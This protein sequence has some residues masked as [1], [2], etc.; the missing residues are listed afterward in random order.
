MSTL[1]QQRWTA[2]EVIAQN[3]ERFTVIDFDFRP[4]AYLR[5]FTPEEVDA[6]FEV[7][8]IEPS[9]TT[10]QILE[11]YK[12]AAAEYHPDVIGTGD[13]KLFVLLQVAKRIAVA[14]VDVNRQHILW[15]GGAELLDCPN[16]KASTRHYLAA[17][18]I[19]TFNYRCRVCKHTHISPLSTTGE[20][21]NRGINMRRSAVI[22]GCDIPLI[23][24]QYANLPAY[25]RGE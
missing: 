5:K 19:Y 24:Q 17:V 2:R 20:K 16:C 14:C 21:R 23:V 1:Q 11:C 7:L 9:S 13:T 3:G 8:D 12:I 15:V 22:L 4:W 25:R 6:A 18:T 10:H